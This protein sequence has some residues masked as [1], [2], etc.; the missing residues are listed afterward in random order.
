M[1]KLTAVGLKRLVKVGVTGVGLSFT[2]LSLERLE[3]QGLAGVDVFSGCT[4][5]PPLVW[6]G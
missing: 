1:Y 2:A 3:V 6:N 5:S 4:S